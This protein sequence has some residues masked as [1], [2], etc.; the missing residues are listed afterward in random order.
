MN[1]RTDLPNMIFNII[2]YRLL[3]DYLY[4]NL[5][6]LQFLIREMQMANHKLPFANYGVGDP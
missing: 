3:A 2:N 4:F 5:L 6:I 1:Y